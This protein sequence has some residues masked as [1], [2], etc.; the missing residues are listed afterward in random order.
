MHICRVPIGGDS[1]H[2]G[3][4]VS[5]FSAYEPAQRGTRGVAPGPHETRPTQS[6][7]AMP[8]HKPYRRTH[9]VVALVQF[10][11]ASRL[12]YAVCVARPPSAAELAHCVAH[13]GRPEQPGSFS[14][15]FGRTHA[16]AHIW[17]SRL[18]AKVRVGASCV[19]AGRRLAGG[20]QINL[21]LGQGETPP[22][23]GHS[24]HPGSPGLVLHGK[25]YCAVCVRPAS[26]QVR[27]EA[28]THTHTR[29]HV[30][31]V[32]ARPLRQH[33]ALYNRLLE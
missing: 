21:I 9:P 32:C 24:E 13:G 8:R 10:P 20:F 28:H 6:L 30:P 25:P 4:A 33:V 14:G 16:C 18:Y 26:P 23:A 31:G 3:N 11:K 22:D 15:A 27:P 5:R 2:Q 12:I 29:C 19:Y 17:A 1:S 7:W